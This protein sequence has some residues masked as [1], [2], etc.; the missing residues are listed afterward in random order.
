MEPNGELI[1]HALQEK[2]WILVQGNC[3][4]ASRLAFVWKRCGEPYLNELPQNLASKYRSLF[5]ATGVKEH[6]STEEVIS[7]LYK[8][9][10]EK[11]GECLSTSEFKV[12]KSLI[13]EIS[14]ASEKSFETERGRIPLPDHNLILQPAEKLAIDDAPWVAPRSCIDYVHKD[15]SIDLA[16]RLGAIDIRT[17]KLSR[18]SRPIGREFGQREELTD[19]LKGILKAYP[20]DVGVLK[21]LVQNA[22]DAGATEIHFIVDPR[23]HPTDQLLSDNWTELQGPAL[24]VYNNRPFSEDDLEGIQRLGIGSKT[25]DPAKTGQYGIGFNAV[26]HLTDCPSF[27]TNGDKLCILDPH[28]RYAPEATKEN[29]GRLIGPIG[30]EE[31]SDFRDVFPCYLENLFDLKSATMF[32]FPL[33]R[34]STSSISQKHVSCTEMMTFMNLLAYEAKEII[35]FLNH[36]KTITLSEIKGNQL[37]EI[38]S[39]SAQLTQ[40]DE[41]QRV[42]LANHVKISKTLETNQIEWLTYP[43]L[44]QEHGLRQ[45]KW[46]IH[47]C[48]GL[49]T[50][51]RS[52]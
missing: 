28:C 24:C 33:R 46:L 4:S 19:R 37:N 9:A 44:I 15:L 41:A 18:I 13:E 30:A 35:L 7:A 26:Y 29:P 8:L 20:C 38:H 16:H 50:S 25:D 45:K 5:K 48:I 32:R 49:Q 27:I 12:S 17:K 36:V 3:L 23:N 52:S 22:D 1:P 47:Q 14:E 10:E 42:R 34:Q 51:T 21:E 40:H 31:R 43:L 2:N 6:F 39:V 11:Q